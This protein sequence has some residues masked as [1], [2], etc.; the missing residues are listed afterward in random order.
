M[1]LYSLLISRPW[2]VCS[3]TT[4]VS[5]LP[6]KMLSQGLGTPRPNIL[7]LQLEIPL[8]TVNHL[9]KLAF[10][11]GISV[12]FNPAP[13][14]TLPE[15]IYPRLHTLIVN[16]GEAAVLSGWE[17]VYLFYFSV[18]SSFIS[19]NRF[20]VSSDWLRGF[21]FGFSAKQ[22]YCRVRRVFFRI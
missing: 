4:F 13:A 17:S 21:S 15:E 6:T 18:P 1:V 12:I 10:N 19:L 11:N 16:E 5:L 9:T 3:L 22:I 7:I 8:E 14:V 20:T 2:K